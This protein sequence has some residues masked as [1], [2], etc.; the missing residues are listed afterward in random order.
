MLEKRA[1]A[2]SRRLHFMQ[3]KRPSYL[4]TPPLFPVRRGKN[5]VVAHP[6]E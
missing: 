1:Q 2:T 4:L 5:Y 6:N 3:K